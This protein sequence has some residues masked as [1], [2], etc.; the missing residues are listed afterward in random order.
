M[1]DQIYTYYKSQY[2]NY[3]HLRTDVF[4]LLPCPNPAS[5]CST[6]LLEPEVGADEGRTACLKLSE[7]TLP[8]Q[9]QQTI[10]ALQAGMVT[11]KV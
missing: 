2:H 8:H 1:K 9:P 4:R 6:K 10:A 7:N 5:F 3:K 11:Q